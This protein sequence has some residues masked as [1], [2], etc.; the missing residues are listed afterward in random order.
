MKNQNFSNEGTCKR[1]GKEKQ[2]TVE[3]GSREQ[4]I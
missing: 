3:M 4:L 1:A 2:D